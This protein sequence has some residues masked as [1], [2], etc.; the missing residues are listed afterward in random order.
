MNSAAK[1]AYT[2]AEFN[3]GVFELKPKTK[4]D[5]RTSIRSG[6]HEMDADTQETF[7]NLDTKSIT[8]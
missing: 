4:L 8:F 7:P 2:F 1:E 5:C 3:D 6:F